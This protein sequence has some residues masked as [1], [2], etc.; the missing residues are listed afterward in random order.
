MNRLFRGLMVSTGV[1]LMLT[2][3]A[4]ISVQPGSQYATKQMPKKVYVEVFSTDKA[5]INADREGKE[6]AEFKT[7][8]QNMM[9]AGITEDMTE[10]LVPAVDGRKH[11]PKPGE[12][13]WVVRGQFVQVN[14]GSRALRGIVGFGAGGTKMLTKVQN[15][16]R[17]KRGVDLLIQFKE[18]IPQAYRGQTDPYFDNALKGLAKQKQQ[19]G[20]ADQAEYINSK[21]TKGF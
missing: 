17:I 20:K 14:Q 21:L 5:V 1:V 11:H 7:G 8:L 4:S 3:C 12:N 6:L 15:T 9:M 2:G 18:A 16:A 13:A 10:R 19:E